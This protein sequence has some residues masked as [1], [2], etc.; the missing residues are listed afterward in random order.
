MNTKIQ[1]IL[2]PFVF[3]FVSITSS[4]QVHLQ[5]GFYINQQN[6]TIS[7]LFDSRIGITHPDYI[8]FKK[9]AES[10]QIQLTP[11]TAKY[12]RFGD[13]YLRSA[14][15]EIETSSLNMDELE[16]VPDFNLINT[17]AFVS[18]LSSGSKSLFEHISSS[19]RK[20]YYVE[21]NGELKLLKYKK[22]LRWVKRDYDKKTIRTEVESKIYV[23]QLRYYLNACDKIKSDITKAEYSAKDFIEIFDTYF[24][25]IGE[26]VDTKQKERKV[27]NYVSAFA[28]VTN[29]S[30]NFSGDD[31]PYMAEV[32][33]PSSTDI[34][35][36]ASLNTIFPQMQEKFI[37]VNEIIFSYGSTE[38]YYHDIDPIS[39][40]VEMTSKIRMSHTKLASSVRYQMPIGGTHLFLSA[41]AYLA[42]VSFQVNER[43]AEYQVRTY[44]REAIPNAKGTDIGFIAGMGIS[45]K[46][47][48]TQV[49]YEK[50]GS[51][52]EADLNTDIGRLYCTIG[53][54]F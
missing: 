27:K 34:T 2:A 13:I 7:G 22:Y 37:W 50:G 52:S 8:L 53:Y 16:W 47:F 40:E 54:R 15:I 10:S 11:E 48:E 21:I 1:Y 39:G 41:G 46:S 5:E 24:E 43:I 26:K 6:D 38:G 19:G 49:R 36:G 45:Y 23:G 20:N 32:N 14:D 44:K 28:G 29:T 30:F 18:V 42:S 17:K 3:T 51:L 33:F 31:F 12:V 9:N 25:C 35:F 4:A